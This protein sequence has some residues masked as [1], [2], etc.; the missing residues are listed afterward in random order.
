MAQNTAPQAP[1]SDQVSDHAA[2]PAPAETQLPKTA[3][4]YPAIGL[5]G[6][7]SLGLYGFVTTRRR[8]LEAARPE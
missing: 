2:A 6:V 4:P 7:L 1:A 8:A 3:S 5:A